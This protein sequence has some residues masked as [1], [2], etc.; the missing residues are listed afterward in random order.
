VC[1]TGSFYVVG[2]A[3][4]HMQEHPNLFQLRRPQAQ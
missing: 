1:V 2:D 4:K 3:L